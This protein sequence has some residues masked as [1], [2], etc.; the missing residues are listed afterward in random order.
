MWKMLLCVTVIAAATG[1]QTYRVLLFPEARHISGFVVDQEGKPVSQ[2]RIDHSSDQQVHQTDS[3]GRFAFD[4]KAPNLVIRKVGFRSALFQNRDATDVRITLTASTSRSFPN[5]SDTRGFESIKGWGASIW[6]PKTPGVK[7]SRQGEDFDYGIRSYVIQTKKNPKG[8]RHGSGALWSFGID[9]SRSLRLAI[10][11]VHRNHIQ[12]R[13]TYDFGCPRGVTERQPV[14][15]SWQIWR[16]RRIFGCGRSD[17]QTP[18]SSSRRGMPELFKSPIGA[19][20]IL[21]VSRGEITKASRLGVAN[22]E[23]RR[24]HFVRLPV[25]RLQETPLAATASASGSHNEHHRRRS[26]TINLA[27]SRSLN[28]GVRLPRIVSMAPRRRAFGSGPTL[29]LRASTAMTCWADC[30]ALRRPGRITSDRYDPALLELESM[31]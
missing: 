5:C 8:I 1:A 4:T 29:S 30:A 2:A 14:E 28:L 17:W 7:A 25:E 13:R 19:H 27:G 3:D 21:I 31:A 9:P 11:W 6:F 10:G 24:R 12:Y 20:V 16:V 26:T 22:A 18:G 15:I 23:I